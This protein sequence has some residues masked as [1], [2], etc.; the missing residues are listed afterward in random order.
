MLG[1]KKFKSNSKLKNSFEYSKRFS[2]PEKRRRTPCNST[3]KKK[4][5]HHKNQS[6]VA[7]RR[8][9]FKLFKYLTVVEGGRRDE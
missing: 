8:G 4:H 7:T 6:S 3:L 9:L 2:A 1:R 5:E